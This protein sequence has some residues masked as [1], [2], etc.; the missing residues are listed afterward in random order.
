MDDGSNV[1]E[2]IIVKFDEAIFKDYYT[3]KVTIDGK[4]FETVEKETTIEIL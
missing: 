4:N 3:I 2:E 1:W